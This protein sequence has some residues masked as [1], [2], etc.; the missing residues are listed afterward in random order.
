MKYMTI[1]EAKK[2]IIDIGKR[3]YMKSFVAAND[4]NITCRVGENKIV[5]TPTGVSK[6]FMTEDMLIVMDLDGNVLEGT[7]KP[8]SEIK[9][10][11]KVFKERKDV[12]GVVHMHP[13]MATA[14][15]IANIPLDKPIL[16]EGILVLGNVY[17][18][19]YAKPGTDE[20]PDSIVPFIHDYNGVLLSNHGALTWGDDV[21]Q[22][23][24]RMEAVEQAA[25]VTSYLKNLT[26]KPNYLSDSA[27]DG[28]IDLREGTYGVMTGGRPKV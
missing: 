24:F 4:G 23:F 28:L 22:A 17:I 25:L 10:H 3:A 9:M 15:S 6:G 7:Y 13:T 1:Q 18:A 2:A 20:I 5:A 21:Y 16:T 27:V 11:L 26:D 19:P 14:C 8:T 12:N